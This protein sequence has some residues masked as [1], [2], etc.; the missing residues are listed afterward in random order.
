[1]LLELS[2]GLLLGCLFFR[3]GFPS[4]F[5]LVLF[6][7]FLLPHASAFFLIGVVSSSLV[8]GI[9][10][11][12]NQRW[13]D[14]LLGVGVA[15]LLL[16]VISFLSSFSFD[17]IVFP[18]LVFSFVWLLFSLP[19]PFFPSFFAFLFILG[20][21]WWLLHERAVPGALPCFLAGWWGLS[22]FPVHE[23]YSFS[24]FQKVR[25]AFL[26]SFLGLLPGFGPGLVNALWFSSNFSPVLGVSNVVFSLGYLSLT[27]HV[28]SIFAA[29]L[30]RGDV[31]S[32]DILFL[33]LL[34]SLIFSRVLFFVFPPAP[35]S[36]S[37][38]VLIIL[39][40][41]AILFVFGPSPFLV[42]GG[43]FFLR[44]VYDFFHFPSEWG[45]L[46]LFPSLYWFYF[47]LA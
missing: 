20:A 3:V 46:I 17:W 39:G 14:I 22:F 1:M 37:P 29:E 33:A 32:L 15:A 9:F 11:F 12:P 16:S 4:L 21:G 36:L 8:G 30:S 19:H 25:D 13:T 6:L 43:A 38:R 42:F 45:S 31:L 7:P 34:F 41:A 10:L 24:F 5:P 26:G 27:G 28:R 2:L 47:P 35:V 40:G 44:L 18:L 23:L